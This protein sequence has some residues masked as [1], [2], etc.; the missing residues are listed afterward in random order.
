MV[1]HPPTGDVFSKPFTGERV[2]P[3]WPQKISL[4]NTKTVLVV[5]RF[6]RNLLEVISPEAGRLPFIAPAVRGYLEQPGGQRGT[7]VW[8]PLG[9][10]VDLKLGEEHF[11]AAY[12]LKILP[13]PFS[14]ELVE[15][16]VPRVPGSERPENFISMIRFCESNVNHSV[17]KQIRMNHPASYPGGWLRSAL[18]LNIKFSQAGWDPAHPDQTVLQ[19][20]YDPGWGLKWLGALATCAG[21]MI[22][23]YFSPRWRKE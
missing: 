4:P 20:V 18:G 15:F 23:L 8:M 1:E 21:A 3:W 2:L 5:D 19:A 22:L 17:E 16:N 12:S 10:P 14:L 11:R 9:V 7:A 13:L 6:T